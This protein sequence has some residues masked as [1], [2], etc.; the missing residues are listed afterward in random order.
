MTLQLYLD[1]DWPL[2]DGVEAVTLFRKQPAG[3]FDAGVVVPH[4]V[5]VDRLKTAE[6]SGEGRL[7]LRKL[8][9]LLCP[10][11]CSPAGQAPP[12][13]DDVIQDGSAVRWSA[14]SVRTY[15]LGS[16]HEVQTTQEV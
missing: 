14:D 8:T 15:P 13:Q 4:A 10:A 3:T 5:R 7:M 6:M 16:T 11:E 12:K 1:D 9:W 2:I